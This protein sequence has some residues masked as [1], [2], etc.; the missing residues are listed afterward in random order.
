MVTINDIVNDDVFGR[1]LD[2]IFFRVYWIDTKEEW[3]RYYAALS[4]V[5]LLTSPDF[6][7]KEDFFEKVAKCGVWNL[8]FGKGFML[9]EI[10]GFTPL[11]KSKKFLFKKVWLEQENMYDLIGFTKKWDHLH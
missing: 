3:H 10:S 6:K 8:N 4:D 9:F 2:R 7:D 11:V 5:H 1:Q